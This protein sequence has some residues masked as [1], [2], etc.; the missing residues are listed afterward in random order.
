MGDGEQHIH[1]HSSSLAIISLKKKKTVPNRIDGYNVPFFVLLVILF[2][3]YKIM[4]DQHD[5][6]GR[7]KWDGCG[8][9]A[10]FL[11]FHMNVLIYC[12]LYLLNL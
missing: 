8:E 6:L 2:F 11:S 7:Y 1:R 5:L 10:L 9:N 12:K 3:I 4:D